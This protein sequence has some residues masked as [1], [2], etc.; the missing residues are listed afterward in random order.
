MQENKVEASILKAEITRQ[1]KTYKQKKIKKLKY[2]AMIEKFE[3]KFK[4]ILKANVQIREIN[5]PF[6]ITA[7]KTDSNLNLMEND[8]H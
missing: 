5:S 1:S 6:Y 4:E 2:K 3:G 7:L 8:K